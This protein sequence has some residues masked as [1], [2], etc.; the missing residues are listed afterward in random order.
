MKT[1]EIVGYKRAN[2][3]RKA[4]QDLRNEGMVPGVL[5]GGEEQIAFYAP[6]YLFRPLIFTSDAYRVKVNIEGTV[7][8]AILQ[9]KQYHPVND[10]LIHA[11]FFIVN[12]EKVVKIKVP[13]RLNGVSRGQRSGGKLLHKLRQLTVRGRVMDIPEYV[14]VDIT[15]LRLGKSIK[16]KSIELADLEILDSLDNPIASV[17]V[18]RSVTEVDDDEPTEDAEGIEGEDEA[19]TAAE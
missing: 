2:L 7:Y 12:D 5:Y 11:D 1:T 10:T 15:D 4:A 17:N 9:E 18:P 19:E 13:I 3:G 8:D 14:D 6:A 16:V